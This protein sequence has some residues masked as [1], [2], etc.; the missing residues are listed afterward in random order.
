M[1]TEALP[2]AVQTVTLC[3]CGCGESF[4]P[5]TNRN[6]LPRRFYT[7]AC[8]ARANRQQAEEDLTEALRTALKRRV[9]VRKALLEALKDG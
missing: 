1:D 5:G 6:G 4:P 7:D 2:E 8:R 9:G 3:A